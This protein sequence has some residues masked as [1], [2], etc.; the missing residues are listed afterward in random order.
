MAKKRPGVKQSKDRLFRQ[1]K[2]KKDMKEAKK[3]VDIAKQPVTRGELF[4]IQNTLNARTDS[5]LMG[6]AAVVD[7]LVK[8]K[9]CT[10]EDF[11][12]GEKSMLE[13]L[14]FIR[15]TMNEAYKELGQ[16]AKS[17]DVGAFIYEKA[18]IFGVNKEVL[19][20][21]FGVKPSES[22]IIKPS[23]EKTIIVP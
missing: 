5:S 8:N 6:V 12:T 20:N 1:L 15:K 23:Q 7:V 19:I 2:A 11:K 21:I 16:D 18:I 9:L 4:G 14:R 3:V 10:Y 17:E 22:R 13:T